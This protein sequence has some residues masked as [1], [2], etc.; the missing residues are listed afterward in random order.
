MKVIVIGGGVVGTV[1]SLLLNMRGVSVT[2]IDAGLQRPGYPLV[3]SKLLRF[4]EDI[5]LAKVSENIYRDLSRHLGM[6]VLHDIASITIV[7]QDCYEGEIKDL[8][9]IWKDAGVKTE[10]YFNASD[11]K[12]YGLK[13]VQSDEVYVVSNGGDHLVNMPKLM[14][15]VRR[16]RDI[17]YINGKASIKRNKQNIE[18]L[19][20]GDRYVGDHVV[21]AAGA[22]N[23]IIMRNVDVKLPLLPYKCQAAAFLS[24]R[25]NGIVYDYVLDIYIRP[26]TPMLSSLLGRFGLS[27]IAAGDGNTEIKEPGTNGYIDE[28]FLSELMSKLRLRVGRV[29]RVG[30]RFGYCEGTPDMRPVIVPLLKD[31]LYLIGGFNGYGAEV[32]PALA[33]AVTEQL[34]NGTWPRYAEPYLVSRF[35]NAQ[36]FVWDI[37]KEA[38]E[39]CVD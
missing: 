8:L 24:S 3:H 22:W 27:I 33:L 34:L 14:D 32:G 13:S 30:A 4:R 28:G 10:V 16:S 26:L 19:V 21:I 7:K 11:I 23:S 37:N 15:H 38:H 35:G 39:L 20:N 18:V 2:L 9:T 29:L 31:R 6:N 12:D 17:V 1:L 36:D 5:E 25:V